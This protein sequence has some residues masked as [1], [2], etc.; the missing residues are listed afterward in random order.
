MNKGRRHGP[1]VGEALAHH[2]VIERACA[3]GAHGSGRRLRRAPDP[4]AA[5]VAASTKLAENGLSLRAPSHSARV[6]AGRV[7]AAMVAVSGGLAS[8]GALGCVPLRGVFDAATLLFMA[9]ALARL[10]AAFAPRLAEGAVPVR[11]AEIAPGWTIIVA[12]HKEASVVGGL[13]A[14]LDQLQWPKSKLSLI[15]V[16]EDDDAETLAAIAAARAR[17]ALRLLV[18]PPGKVRTKPRA[19]QAALPFVRT[20]FVTVY[21]AEDRP[22]PSQLR[23]AFQAFT[24]GPANLAVVQAPLVAWNHTESWIAGQF[25]LDYAIWFRVMLPALAHVSGFLPLGGTSN[26]FRV[27]ALRACGGWD[28]W[29]VTEDADLGARLARSGWRAG[30]IAPPTWEEA[31]PRIAGWVRQRGRWIQGH[32]QTVGVHGRQPVRAARELGLW[33]TVAFI[34]GIACGPMAA[35]LSAP[36]AVAAISA[37]ASGC[38]EPATQAALALAAV[39]HGVTGLVAVRRDGRFRLALGL[40]TA[41]ACHLLQL[42]ALARAIWRVFCT[43]HTWDKTEHGEAARRPWTGLSP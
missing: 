37:L 8:A 15:L 16:C 42:P 1:S 43:P 24:R 28:P 25:A 10:A 39:S 33:G 4:P 22:D 20:A 13:L 23:A 2:R 31:P 17:H 19:L 3:R 35:A 34:L 36:F 11:P 18:L 14:A 26:H 38:L 21:D 5:L 6:P 12:L 7:F 32:V 40:F 29:N 41:P 30:L 9:I 27:A